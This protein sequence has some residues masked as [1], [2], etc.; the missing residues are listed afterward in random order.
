MPSVPVSPDEPDSPA[1]DRVAPAAVRSTDQARDYA[2]M[3]E[4]YLRQPDSAAEADDWTN[5]GEF[6]P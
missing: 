3:R 6:D 1:R 5:A 4:G 2:K